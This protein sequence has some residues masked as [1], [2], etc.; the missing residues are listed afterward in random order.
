MH[1][2]L[3][4]LGRPRLSILGGQMQLPRVAS[5]GKTGALAVLA[6]VVLT[7][8]LSV[9]ARR[10]LT[11]PGQLEIVDSAGQVVGHHASNMFE[12]TLSAM[13][14]VDQKF[15]L[16]AVSRNGFFSFGR[17]FYTQ[18]NCQGQAWLDA[19]EG[20]CGGMCTS[21]E[22]GAPGQTLYAP[23]P[24]V[25]PQTMTFLSLLDS[26]G[27]SSAFG[28]SALAARAVPV[29]DLNT[30]FTPPFS[31]RSGVAQPPQPP[32]LPLCT[33]GTPPGPGWVQVGSGGWVPP[34]HPLEAEGVCRAK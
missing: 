8:G 11:V 28:Q 25:P 23:D 5:V 2:L 1:G 31:L 4:K 21:S 15:Y 10:A 26:R 14:E 24:A 3:V 9:S 16:V 13:L 32:G 17:F 6:I 30:V 27:C 22:V 33:S 7:V 20:T 29:I 18:P 12:G 19:E 34:G